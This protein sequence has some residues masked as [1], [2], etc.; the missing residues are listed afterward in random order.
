MTPKTKVS[1]KCNSSLGN[2]DV[3]ARATHLK[4]VIGKVSLTTIER[5]IMSTKTTIKRIALVAAA[6]LGL[7]VLSV[8]PAQA[9]IGGLTVTV[10]SGT[11]TLGTADSTTAATIALSGTMD[12]GDSLTI[13]AIAV[14]QPS[15][16]SKFRAVWMNLDSNTPTANS[17]TIVETTTAPGRG[18]TAGVAFAVANDPS[19]TRVDTA[20]SDAAASE[21]GI[22][23]RRATSSAYFS[24]NIGLQLDSTTAFNQRVA[25]TYA[26]KV[27][28]KTFNSGSS[29]NMSPTQA[30][31]TS[32]S[33][34][35]N[36]VVSDGSL[37]ASGSVTAAGTSS[38]IM[39]GTSGTGTT[40]LNTNV[41]SVISSVATPSTSNAAAVIQL[42]QL[43]SA[44]LPARESITA[45]T[46]I[47]NVGDCSSTIGK[48]VVLKAS[49]T[50]LDYICVFPDGTG[51]VATINLK[52]TSVTFAP[53]KVTF[54]STTVAKIEAGLLGKTLG[55]SSTAVILAKAY[56]AVGTQIVGNS[57]VYA[58][59]DALTVINTG[60]STGTECT[61]VAAYGGHVCSLAGAAN[62]TANITLR[63]KS[64]V[65]LST[66]SFSTGLAIAV[67]SNPAATVKLAFDKATY[68]P[69][70]VAYII[71]TVLDASGNVVGGGA[72]TN[73][74][75]SGGITS[76]VSFG[77]GS[78]TTTSISPTSATTT[79]AGN[80]YAST[81]P[82]VLYKVYMPY[83]GGTV[84]VTA[85]GGTLLPAAGQVAVSASATV[86]DNG[87]SALA[88]V[89][90]LASQVSAF[91][92]KI[93]AQIT[94][95]TDLVM[96]IQKKVKA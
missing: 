17:N 32:A 94:T 2:R 53:K 71:A 50:G 46:D 1:L 61:Y 64:T 45:S 13:Q 34:D 92:T 36:I 90:A 20:V 38:A 24:W 79:L 10:T 40:W 84:K 6:S 54:Y 19:R 58:Y 48:S 57:S 14:S 16:V 39:S 52:T 18:S 7:G 33:Y 41:D 59:S 25:G 95:L 81:D 86:T 4:A 42:T 85:T 91:I 15:G 26:F 43:T 88:A 80:G 75:A 76:T 5:K 21:N 83:S 8:V 72:K 12:A 28:V 30:P 69:G 62:G 65:A 27:V 35:V 82:I 55:T 96:K 70:E 37:A 89:T 29:A 93:N 9:T 74:F 68:A 77:N 56:D 49:T 11:A 73:L 23:I 78:D 51:G 67:N 47:G 60:T 3:S 66:V 87:A 22:K 31:D 63:N 44:G